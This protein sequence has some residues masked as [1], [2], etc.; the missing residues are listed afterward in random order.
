MKKLMV[1]AATLLLSASLTQAQTSAAA[2]TNASANSETSVSASHNGV[3]AQSNTS[4]SSS[5]D[6]HT[7]RSKRHPKEA[8]NGGQNASAAGSS[9][10]AGGTMVNAALT[11]PVDTKSCKP[12]DPVMAKTTQDV[13]SDSG[14]VIPKG[15]R[16]VG[17]VTEA[18]T[19]AKGENPSALGIAFDHAVLKNGQQVPFNSTI[20][21]VAAAQMAGNAA[22]ADDSMAAST[23]GSMA[24]SGQVAGGGLLRG[25][26]ST[27]G[28]TAGTVT[29][30]TSGVGGT[31]NSATSVAGGVSGQ[32]S[33]NATGVIGMPGVSLASDLSSAT[34]GSVLTSAGKNI[35][36]ESGTQMVL[37]VVG[38]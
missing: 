11:K 28:S 2:Q 22:L 4:A 7:S 6:V 12:G 37:R 15:S 5:T 18:R 31:L 26:S 17:H 3:N 19:R 36:L 23:A 29:H 1:S 34:T 21:A 25:V 38:Q 16:L 27:A 32:L 24:G 13:K 8:E 20:Q 10:L 14:V 9:Q 30:A 33:Q 35:R